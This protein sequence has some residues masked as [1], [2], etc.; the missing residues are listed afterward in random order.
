MLRDYSPD[1]S[2]IV[3]NRRYRAVLLRGPCVR[4]SCAPAMRIVLIAQAGA[5][6]DCFICEKSVARSRVARRRRYAAHAWSND[7]R[8]G[9]RRGAEEGDSSFPKQTAGRIEDFHN[10]Q[11]YTLQIHTGTIRAAIRYRILARGQPTQDYDAPLPNSID[12]PEGGGPR[13]RLTFDHL[14]VSG[15]RT[16]ASGAVCS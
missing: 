8:Q 9:L 3:T 4:Q 16:T 11:D 6:E 13:E 5:G 1:V 7:Q 2:R 10:I 15:V 12:N 14:R